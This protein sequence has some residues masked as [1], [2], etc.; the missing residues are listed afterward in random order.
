MDRLSKIIV[1]YRCRLV[2]SRSRRLAERESAN[3]Q[4]HQELIGHTLDSASYNAHGHF[5]GRQGAHEMVQSDAHMQ[6]S[7]EASRGKPYI[8]QGV[9]NTA[10]KDGS[11]GSDDNQQATDDY[12]KAGTDE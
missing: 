10:T 3:R 7:G 11:V 6:G 5:V 9:L 8:P 4:H 2:Q 12:G 1:E